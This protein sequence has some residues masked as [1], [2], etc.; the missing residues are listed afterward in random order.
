MP[1]RGHNE[2]VAKTI[3]DNPTYREA[4]RMVE[5]TIIGQL[6]NLDL[7]DQKTEHELVLLLRAGEQHH[8]MM[9]GYIMSGEIS[10]INAQRRKSVV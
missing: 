7:D 1:R 3:V 4:R 6:K 8:R 9:E 5:E 2:T 10:D